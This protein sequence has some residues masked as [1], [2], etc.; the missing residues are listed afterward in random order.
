[1]AYFPSCLGLGLLP[2][3]V[4]AG[5]R[6]LERQGLSVHIPPEQICCGQALFK[7][8]HREQA[9]RVGAA[10]VRAMSGAPAVVGLSG[11]CVAH[12]RNHL[13]ELLAP[14][15]ALAAEARRLASLT[16]ELT[17]FVVRQLGVEDLAQA[18]P[19]E[20]Y[21]YHPS[22]GLHRALGE[23]QTPWLLLRSLRGAPPRELPDSGR[24]CGFGGPF[25]V[26][27]PELSGALLSQKLA[28]LKQTGAR[29]LV[30][31]DLGCMLHLGAGAAAQDPGLRVVHLAQVLA[32]EV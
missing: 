7:A 31:G 17:Q 18:A 16:W 21:A 12:V 20:P 27:H 25:S 30:V 2:Q 26:S 11:S 14:W 6:V 3:V 15:P 19:D 24:C 32:G 9:A 22:C 23:N 29:L 4:R 28:D 1:M 10:W 13:A 8:G 5:R